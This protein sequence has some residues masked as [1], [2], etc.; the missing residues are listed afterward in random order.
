MDVPA[1]SIAN[2]YRHAVLSD[3]DTYRYKLSRQWG[4]DGYFLPIVML[5]PSTADHRVD[6][7]TIKRCMSFA[8]REG[9]IGITVY[10]LFA[11]RSTNPK[12]LM[13]VADPLGPQNPDFWHDALDYAQ[14]RDIPVLCGWGAED[15]AATNARLFVE[16]AKR[17]GTKLVC[18][19]K[20]K[21]NKP[22]H[23]LYISGTQPFEEYSL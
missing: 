13:Q 17:V 2:P 5:N 1:L 21:H 22:R 7:P 10:N 6:D 3:C 20:T 8:D 4:Y 9:F 14:C 11:Y 15:F 23:P 12:A 19:G 18:L 16:E